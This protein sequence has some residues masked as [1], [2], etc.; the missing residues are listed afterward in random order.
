MSWTKRVASL[1]PDFSD[2]PNT[3][4]FMY[5]SSSLYGPTVAIRQVI[6]K[7]EA[8]IR[9]ALK[10]AEISENIKN[11]NICEYLGW[12]REVT[13]EGDCVFYFFYQTLPWN[14]QREINDR[15]N[16]S[17]PFTEAE[18][19]HL[20]A[21]LFQ[22]CCHLQDQGIGHRRINPDNILL[23]FRDGQMHAKLS[24]FGLAKRNDSKNQVPTHTLV[25]NGPYDSPKIR[26]AKITN[27]PYVEHNIFKSDVF[28]LG[29]VFLHVSQLEM[30]VELSN[31]ST[32]QSSINKCLRQLQYSQEWKDLLSTMLQKEE[33]H[34]PDFLELRDQRSRR[35]ANDEELKGPSQVPTN[36]SPLR[37][38]VKCGLPQV[39]VTPQQVDEVPCMVIISAAQWSASRCLYGTDV[40]CV[41]D[42]SGSA[43]DYLLLVKALLRRFVENLKE[44]DRLSLVGFSDDATQLCPLTSGSTSGKEDLFLQINKLQVLDLSNFSTG[45]CRGLEVL[46]QRRYRNHYSSLVVLT[47]GRDNYTAEPT[48]LCMA[49]LQNCGVE[50]LTVSCLGWGSDLNETLLRPLAAPS[51]GLFARITEPGDISRVLTCATGSV[52]NTAATDLRVVLRVLDNDQV[53]SSVTK[54]YSLDPSP[55]TFILPSIKVGEEKH[56]IFQ[57][58][59]EY[60]KLQQSVRFPAVEVSL[61]YLDHENTESSS[62][63]FLDVKWVKSDTPSVQVALV[64]SHYY[65]VLG[66]ETLSEVCNFARKNNLRQAKQLLENRIGHITSTGYGQEAVVKAVLSDLSSA[67]TFLENWSSECEEKLLSLRKKHLLES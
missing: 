32:Y 41:V 29:M 54:V 34:R 36:P 58:K 47:D 66:A 42:L 23:E 52:T 59:P 38:D 53:S 18:L 4:V 67:V 35:Y 39:R 19:W 63:A 33:C 8:R 22:A 65:R 28:S 56:L 20:F 60:R 16:P 26:E 61:T 21:Q 14:L 12:E 43:E 50:K 3:Q 30:P 9:E 51:G 37:L 7:E 49:A 2:E 17:R 15:T 11:Q 1:S 10:D 46:K 45:F 44:Q 13:A 25:G 27:Q 40:V 64:Y 62:T 24:N 48:A 5:K 6:C 55:N 31:M 57:L